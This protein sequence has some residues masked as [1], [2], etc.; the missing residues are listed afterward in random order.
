MKQVLYTYLA[1][2]LS[3]SLV[4]NAQVLDRLRE[5]QANQKGIIAGRV[6]DEATGEELPSANI[7]I[8]GT[9][10]GASADMLGRFVIENINP[11]VYNIDVTLLGYKT[12]Q[13]SAVKVEAGKSLELIVKMSESVL[14]LGQEVVIIGEK[15]L[16]DVE[17]TSS[18][19]TVRSEDLTVAAVTNVKDVVGLQTGVVQSDNEIHIRGSRGYENAYLV[20]G[21]SVQDVL[22]GTGFGL[23]VSPD[24]IQEMEVITGGYNAEFGQ[25]TSGV[26]NI[27]TKEGSDKF[28]GGISYKT[29]KIVGTNSRH[30]FN[31]DI[32]EANVSGPLPVV[33]EILS[34]TVSFF[35][36]ASANV[37]DG[38]TR[39]SPDVRRGIPTGR[40]SYHTPNQ[41]NS[42]IFRGTDWALRL[43]N[44]YSWASKFTWKPSPTFKF[45]YSYNQSVSIDQNTA[46]IKTSLEREEPQPGYQY[47]FQN[48]LDSANTF[49]QVNIQH[50]FSLTHTLSP[51][52][53]YD[54]RISR[55]TAH[56]RGDANGKGFRINPSTGLVEFLYNEPRDI[57][58]L[59]IEYYFPDSIRVGV[60][61]GDGFY[62]VGGPFSWRDH[63]IDEYTVK[64][65]FTNHFT[66]KNKF[67]TGVELKFQNL[68]MVDISQPWIKP[69]GLNNDIYQVSPAS[70]AFY[71]QD[72]ITISGMVLNFGM[73]FDY[74]FPGKF[75]DDAI[76]NPSAPIASEDIRQQYRDNTSLLFGRRWKGRLSPRLGISHP[77]SDNQTLFFSYGHFSKLPRPTY[78]YSKLTESSARSSSQV[79]GNPNL[80]PETTVAYEL[81]IR[82]QI[83]EDDVLTIT[84]YYK[85]IFDYI[86]AR[87]VRATNVRFSRGSYT[88]YVNSDYARTRGFEV[89]YTHRFNTNFRTTVSGSYSIATG[90]SSSATEALFNLSSGG[91]ETSIKEN[92]VPWDRPVQAQVTS[93]LNVK[94]NE[95]LMDFAPGI[96]DDY[97]LYVRGFF[98]SGKRYTGQTF[99]GY[100]AEGRPQYLTDFNNLYQ[101]VGEYWFYINLNFEKYFDIGFAKLTVSLEI[102]NLFDNKNSQIINPVTG[103]AYEYGDDTPTSYNDPRFPDLQ[104]TISPYPYNPARY[105]APRTARA[106]IALRF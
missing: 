94:K 47:E 100:D 25:A 9:Y 30:F 31:T 71:A 51:K 70:G 65:D 1:S 62:D 11:G 98:Q 29:D 46:T 84:T 102:Q 106:G 103:R 60:I 3:L 63:Y 50:T 86:T 26:V 89:E 92:Y 99:T 68:Q 87:S 40:Y 49:T 2:L 39:W 58:S 34:G 95:P 41:L 59:P 101:K 75:V 13:Y 21:V 37:T 22:G 23:Q 69:L 32:L 42:S 78:V 17:E 52:S 90:K 36:S 7:Q 73:R 91:R 44:S 27:T 35:A 96:L 24:A 104:G 4:L 45:G 93:I 28:N 79:I 74:W 66:E 55:Y 97:N 81:G 57:V 19:R 77:V 16:F 83:T 64:L 61:P 14:S 88:T 82:N 10:Y 20:D 56:V 105:L 54:L 67:K 8:K 80:N 72:N 48:I 6:I 85:D 18:K 15:R 38:Y 33:N 5:Q 53:F 12:V 43:A 76:E